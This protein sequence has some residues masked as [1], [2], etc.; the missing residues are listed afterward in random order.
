[1]SRHTPWIAGALALWCVLAPAVSAAQLRD[2]APPPTASEPAP[3]D[4]GADTWI[5]A[6]AAIGCGFFSRATIATGG[7]QAGTWAG[8]ISTCT[9]M[10]FDAM[11]ID[12]K[13]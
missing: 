11:F 12:K 2:P 6:A 8:L 1:M 10:F 9:L 7:T 3:P 5:G 13:R 4:S